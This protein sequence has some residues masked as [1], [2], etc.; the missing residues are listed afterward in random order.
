MA[1]ELGP[2]THSEQS[3]RA[4]ACDGPIRQMSNIDVDQVQERVVFDS[5][6]AF[7]SLA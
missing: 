3:L 1:L 7:D 2:I 6:V 4:I 5:R